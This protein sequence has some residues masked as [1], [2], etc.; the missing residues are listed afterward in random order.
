MH[1]DIQF[2]LAHHVTYASFREPTRLY[3]LG[4]PFV[5]GPVSGAQ[6]YPWRFLWRGGPVGACLEGLRTVGNFC[7][8][9]WS[10]RVHRA[11]KAAALILVSNTETQDRFQRVLNVDSRLCCDVGVDALCSDVGEIPP[12]APK[13]CI[14]WAGLLTPRKALELLLEALAQLPADIRFELHVIG[15]G[16]RRRAWQALARRLGIA[17]HIRW[18]GEI[19]RQQVFAEYRWSDFLAFTSLR[20]TTG[21]VVLEAMAAGRPVV[22]L[23]H[24]GAGDVVTLDCG[25]KVPVTTRAEVVDRLCRA[26]ATLARDRR[27]C[28]LLGRAARRRVANYLWSAEARVIAAHY[29]HLLESVGSDARCQLEPVAASLAGRGPA[30][31]RVLR[32]DAAPASTAGETSPL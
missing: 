15:D 27:R 19:P 1:R 10:R 16:P 2:D 9:H 14:V 30:E 6:D 8:L 17:E 4:I 12:A 3:Q 31:T 18:L 32:P 5:W 26:V 21:T 20:D 7:Q 28:Q 13:I 22:C 29:N 23:D 25:I 11:A 24:Q